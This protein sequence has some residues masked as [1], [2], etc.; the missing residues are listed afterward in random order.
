MVSL[1]QNNMNEMKVRS[2]KQLGCA[3]IMPRNL[4]LRKVR[5]K[6][7]FILFRRL[8]VVDQYSHRRE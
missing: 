3:G 2:C 4:H 8:L 6:I 7:L 5:H 1:E